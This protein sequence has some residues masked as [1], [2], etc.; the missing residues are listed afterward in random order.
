MK[1]LIMKKTG[2]SSLDV[3]LAT[4]L[5]STT[6]ALV[7]ALGGHLAGSIAAAL[8]VGV[9]ALTDR[10]VL[11]DLNTRIGDARTTINRTLEHLHAASEAAGKLSEN[12]IAEMITAA[13]VSTLATRDV[14]VNGTTT[15]QA[16]QVAP[17]GKPDHGHADV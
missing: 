6:G 4:F 17:E 5:A 14:L 13:G 3:G 12:G 2:L 10:W 11:G 1:N 15:R 7:L 16:P 8:V 9:I